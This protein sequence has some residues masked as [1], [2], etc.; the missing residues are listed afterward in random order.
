MGL[1]GQVCVTASCA[2]GEDTEPMSVHL[3]T[4]P[5]GLQ[6]CSGKKPFS[7]LLCQQ[8][9]ANNEDSV[10]CWGSFFVFCLQMAPHGHFQASALLNCLAR[11]GETS[12]SSLKLSQEY[13][14]VQSS[15]TSCC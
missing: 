4:G 1:A 8:T 12:V 9:W 15:G 7:S 6:R 13:L 10:V 5:R 14:A 3:P 2:T 11:A